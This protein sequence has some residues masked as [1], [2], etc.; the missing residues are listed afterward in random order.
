[1]SSTQTI[2]STFSLELRVPNNNPGFWSRDPMSFAC[3]IIHGYNM[4]NK[5]YLLYIVPHS[6]NSTEQS[7]NDSF[8]SGLKDKRAQ[9]S[10]ISD[11]VDS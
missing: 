8:R 10:I 4:L 5:K 6:K 11:R 9:L 7:D 3:V 2:K 1:M